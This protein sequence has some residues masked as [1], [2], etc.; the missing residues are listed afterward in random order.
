M[1]DAFYEKSAEEYTAVAKKA[2]KE[3]KDHE[4]EM[5]APPIT[6]DFE[7]LQAV[8]QDVI[9]WIYCEGTDINYPV[10]QGEDNEFYL[11]HTYDGASNRAGSIFVDA[12]NAPC[13]ADSNTIIY[14]HHM[15]NGSMFAALGNWAKQDY[16]ETH[17][18]FWLLTPE[19]NYCVLLFSGYTTSAVSGTYTI[20][21]GPGREFSEYLQAVCANSDFRA[22]IEPDP[23]GKCVVLS[24]CEYDFE[25]ARYVLHGMLVPCDAN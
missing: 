3:D 13:F 19:Q 10:L 24:T 17:P 21:Q 7:K 8:N 16:Y 25:N 4:E 22:D 1:T 9:G 6:V 12:L 14:G 11:K 20:F 5:K 2:P 23:N 15:K 18:I